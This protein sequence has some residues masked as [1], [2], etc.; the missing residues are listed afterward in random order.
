MALWLQVR[1]QVLKKH[2]IEKFKE[3][4]KSEQKWTE[5]ELELFFKLYP[6]YEKYKNNKSRAKLSIK[7]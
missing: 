1:I 6:Q 4:L 3:G 7:L 5:E 2:G